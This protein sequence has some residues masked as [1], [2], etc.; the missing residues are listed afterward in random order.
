[1]QSCAMLTPAYRI[2]CF[3]REHTLADRPHASLWLAKTYAVS[4][5]S[6]GVKQTITNWAVLRGCEHQPL[7]CY[8][9][10]AAVKLYKS[11]PAT[12]NSTLCRDVQANL[13]LQSK[14]DK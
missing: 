11:M 9:Y 13:K 10:K 6:S 3:E 1:M 7:Q 2:C 5:G 8:W 14:D 12:N 4:A